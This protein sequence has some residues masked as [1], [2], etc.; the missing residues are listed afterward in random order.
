[1]PKNYKIYQRDTPQP[2]RKSSEK[3]IEGALLERE[4]KKHFL[5]PKDLAERKVEK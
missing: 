1:V 5:D 2:N 4:T 3:E